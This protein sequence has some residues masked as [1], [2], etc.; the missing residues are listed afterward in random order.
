MVPLEAS[1]TLLRPTDMLRGLPTDVLRL[2][3][4]GLD[5]LRLGLNELLLRLGLLRLRLLLNELLLRL[6]VDML[7]LGVDMLR[8]GDD[9]LRLG[10]DMLRLGVDMLRLG[11]ET[12]RLGLLM[13]R[14]PPPR[15]ASA[16]VKL[17][18]SPTIISAIKFL[19]FILLLL[20]C[21]IIIAFLFCCKN[22]KKLR[23]KFPGVQLFFPKTKV[24]F[25]VG[26]SN[27]SDVA[28]RGDDIAGSEEH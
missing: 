9:M 12:L 2:L 4:V 18:A 5:V 10:V 22:R 17:S 16:G 24:P 26:Q 23:G 25:P 6:G 19:V 3:N 14:L 20:S 11:A 28:A 15:W 13:L 7:R 27:L 1:G 8:L 21:W